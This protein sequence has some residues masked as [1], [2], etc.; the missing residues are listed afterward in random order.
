MQEKNE[1]NH[2]EHLEQC[3]KNN[4]DIKNLINTKA[5]INDGCSVF[6]KCILKYQNLTHLKGYFFERYKDQFSINNYSNYIA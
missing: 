3:L 6:A 5:L 2:L 1:K 4:I